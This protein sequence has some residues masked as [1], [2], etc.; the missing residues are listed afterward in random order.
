LHI[1]IINF[2]APFLRNIK[3]SRK[4]VILINLKANIF[5]MN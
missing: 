3:L 4:E 2:I 5:Q 1:Y